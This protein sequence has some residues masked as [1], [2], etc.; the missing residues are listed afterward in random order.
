MDIRLAHYNPNFAQ[1]ARKL[2][3][4]SIGER[5]ISDLPVRPKGRFGG[6]KRLCFLSGPVLGC[7]C[8]PSPPPW[9][10][11]PT[12]DEAPCCFWVVG[13][14]P[15]GESVTLEC[16]VPGQGSWSSLLEPGLKDGEASPCTPPI[17]LWPR[18]VA[19][20]LCRQP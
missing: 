20:V 5:P 10:P 7:H 19:P 17:A 4:E 16:C 18:M 13:K 6:N 15:S 8:S 3:V 9:V 14:Q 11:H 1:A 12:R 2:N